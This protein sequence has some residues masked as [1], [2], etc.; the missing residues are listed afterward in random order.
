M[1][2]TNL[3]ITHVT[4]SALAVAGIQWLKNSPLFPWVTKEKNLLLRLLAIAT[5]AAS[6]LSI[7]YTWNPTD[8][9][10]TI[11]GLTLSGI[12]M[13]AW[14]WIKSFALQELTYRAV[15]PSTTS[16]SVPAAAVSSAPA[17]V[18]NAAKA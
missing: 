5:A 2:D 14:A 1:A 9:S 4:T 8:H 6:A 16:A 11:T 15:K 13:A 10:L 18:A 17:T 12:G 7:N 3:V